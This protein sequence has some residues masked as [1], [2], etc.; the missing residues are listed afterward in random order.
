M[1]ELFEA[2]RVCVEKLSVLYQLFK[3]E[4]Y[5]KLQSVVQV[6]GLSA[7]INYKKELQNAELYEAFRAEAQTIYI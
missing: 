3:Y 1:E 4:F 5:V 6:C 7:E 2:L